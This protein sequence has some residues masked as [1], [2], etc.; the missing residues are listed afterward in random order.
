[1][2]VPVTRIGGETAIDTLSSMRA[3]SMRERFREQIRSAVLEAAHDLIVE[4]GWDRVRMGEVADRAGV[5]RAALYNE[6]GDKAGL[7]EA[8]VLREASRFLEGIQ[9]ALEAHVGEAK[10]GIAAAVDYTLDEAERSPLLKAV[11]ISNRDLDAQT[12]KS[13]GMLPLLTT[14][15]RLLELA[16]DTLAGWVA[17]HFPA[18]PEVDVIDAADTLVRLTVSHLA[19]PR[20]DRAATARRISEVAVRYLRLDA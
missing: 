5:S 15:A 12:Q 9:G 3:P 20:W 18:L 7:G 11:L 2:S 1:M 6:F 8:V 4:R 13:T 19:L 14:S 17:E 16:S 10:D